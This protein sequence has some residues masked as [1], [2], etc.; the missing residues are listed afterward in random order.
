MNTRGRFLRAADEVFAKPAPPAAE[1]VG[2]IAA[3]VDHK[4]RFVFK[5]R[6]EKGG[7]LLLRH[8]VTGKDL[9]PV[10]KGKRRRHVVL[11]GER[12]APGGKHLSSA[13]CESLGKVCGFRLHVDRHGYAKSLEGALLR[14]A[15][16]DGIEHRHIR[17]CPIDFLP[18]RRG[19]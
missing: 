9:H 14:E 16:A 15:F 6:F 4:M 19:E 5:R 3:V 17:A 1:Q 2:K 11:G 8:S 10:R 12:V 13:D 18:A 7:V